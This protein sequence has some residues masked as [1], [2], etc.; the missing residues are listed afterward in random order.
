MEEHV[1]LRGFYFIVVIGPEYDGYGSK[2]KSKGEGKSKSKTSKGK[3]TLR[4]FPF[5]KALY[6]AFLASIITLSFDYKSIILLGLTSSY[7]LRFKR[8]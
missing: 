8:F 4:R 7:D 6:I 2:G 3:G 1:L 5:E